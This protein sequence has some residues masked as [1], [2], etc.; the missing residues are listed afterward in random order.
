MPEIYEC[1][2]NLSELL[3]LIPSQ[4]YNNDEEIQN[5]ECEIQ[6]NMEQNRIK[7]F[8]QFGYQV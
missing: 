6:N 4:Q 1:F 3:R 5:L 2:F 8:G 7:L